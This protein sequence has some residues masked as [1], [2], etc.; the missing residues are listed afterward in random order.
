[1]KKYINLSLCGCKEQILNK[2]ELDSLELGFY[3]D[4]IVANV[5]DDNWNDWTEIVFLLEESV[6]VPVELD[7]KSIYNLVCS[8]C[9]NV[10]FGTMDCY[11]SRATLDD[12]ALQLDSI[13]K[14]EEFRK[15][16]DLNYLRSQFEDRDWMDF[17]PDYISDEE[18]D[19]YES[20]NE[21]ELQGAR[22]IRFE[23][24][25]FYNIEDY[26][27]SELNQPFGT[28]SRFEAQSLLVK[29]L[30]GEESEKSSWYGARR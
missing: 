6:P 9:V 8:W 25:T 21:E 16:A 10:A 12:I 17:E 30:T 14:G 19:G 28:F 11:D 29:Y 23:N 5:K 18:I 1:M 4:E 26:L 22:D 2:S 3:K 20:M 7:T 15:M 13:D 24:Y 27:R